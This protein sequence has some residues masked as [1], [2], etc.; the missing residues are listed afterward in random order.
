[1]HRLGKIVDKGED[2]ETYLKSLEEQIT[3][4]EN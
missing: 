4:K 3:V 1:M 2:I